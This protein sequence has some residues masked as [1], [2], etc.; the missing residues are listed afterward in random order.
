MKLNL[1][2][3]DCWKNTQSEQVHCNYFKRLLYKVLEGER[4]NYLPHSIIDNF[5]AEFMVSYMLSTEAF[6]VIDNS[7]LYI[8]FLKQQNQNLQ[9]LSSA[10]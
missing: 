6:E 9:Q 1:E 2:T 10:D 3:S 7:G 5:Y 8:N 4:P